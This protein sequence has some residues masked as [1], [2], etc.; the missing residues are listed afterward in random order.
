L[1]AL[2]DSLQLNFL[3]V[4]LPSH[5][6][7]ERLA[8]SISENE[9]K[10]MKYRTWLNWQL[11]NFPRPSDHGFVISLLPGAIGAANSLDEVIRWLHRLCRFQKCEGLLRNES[12]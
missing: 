12:G 10:K 11:C 4:P 6:S 2:I 8:I 3:F 1:E 5:P 9:L 7:M